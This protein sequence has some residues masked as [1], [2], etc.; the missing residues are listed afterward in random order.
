MFGIDELVA[1][2][3][4]GGA[5]FGVVLAVALLV[6]LRH[7]GDPDHLAAVS[8]L[9]ATDPADGKRRAGRL[10]FAWGL[11]HGT[12]LLVFGLPI[13]LF[14]GYLPSVV[15]HAAEVLVGLVIAALAVRLLVRWRAGAFH[16]HEHHHGPVRHRHLHPHRHASS[17]EHPHDSVQ[18]L[19]RTSR[20]AYGIGLVHGV[21]GS[22]GV[23]I[24]LLA[25]IPDHAE[26]AAA[27]L[28]FAAAAAGSMATLSSLFGYVLTRGP[29]VRRVMAVMPA[30]GVG[31]FAFGTWYALG[32]IG[33]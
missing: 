6:G 8:T 10:G 18:R 19:G 20:Q 16:V 24:L 21:G 27:L 9:I 4:G 31:C 26:A 7:A 30:M 2:L 33:L 5:T 22:A 25:A 15:Q 11:G 14:H 29:V 32:A 13:V 3:M 23:G 12:T 1:D 17:H 28:V